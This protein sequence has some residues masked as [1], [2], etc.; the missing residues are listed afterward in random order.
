MQGAKKDR[1][2]GDEHM[3]IM[4]EF[5][6]AVKDVYPDALIQVCF[7]LLLRSP[8]CMLQFIDSEAL[9]PLSCTKSAADN[10]RR[11]RKLSHP[12]PQ[13]E[14]FQTDMA[15]AILEKMRSKI[16]CFNDDIQ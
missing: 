15:F 9:V 1:I 6:S 4:E 12:V 13:F 7:R 5:C 16:L 10:L 11:Q 14:D 3:A 2:R 8:L